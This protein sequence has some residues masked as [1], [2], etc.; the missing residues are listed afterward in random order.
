MLKTRGSARET[1]DTL[2][3]GEHTLHRSEECEAVPSH[4]TTE[5]AAA[6]ELCVSWNAQYLFPAQHARGGIRTCD[7]LRSPQT[8]ELLASAI[9]P[10]DGGRDSSEDNMDAI[11]GPTRSGTL[12]Y[13]GGSASE[14]DGA[15]TVVFSK[16]ISQ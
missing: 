4:L 11:G 15:A 8:W 12:N 5:A 10:R 14:Q 9:T 7:Q 3:G 2:K 13:D 1:V 6:G 16:Y